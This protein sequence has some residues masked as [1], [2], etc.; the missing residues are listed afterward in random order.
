MYSAAAFGANRPHF[1]QRPR[2]AARPLKFT[3]I[4]ALV[5]DADACLCLFSLLCRSFLGGGFPSPVREGKIGF[6]GLRAASAVGAACSP[7]PQIAVGVCW[8]SAKPPAPPRFFCRRPAAAGLPQ[9]RG[10]HPLPRQCR[11][12]SASG[13]AGSRQRRAAASEDDEGGLLTTL[14]TCKCSGRRRQ[15]AALPASAA[16]GWWLLSAR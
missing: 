7:P 12:M 9:S 8:F 3:R 14:P 1:A 11:G 4:L 5:F 16:T 13:A 10:C 15:P 6:V 2:L